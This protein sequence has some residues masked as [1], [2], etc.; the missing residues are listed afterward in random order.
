MLSRRIR[1]QGV[2]DIQHFLRRAVV[3]CQGDHFGTR[4]EPIRKAQDVLDG[5]GA[6]GIDRLGVVAD[7]REALAIGLQAVEDL[8]LQFIGVL[9][10]VDEHVVE[11]RADVLCEARVRHHQVPVE[12]QIVVIQHVVALFLL[13]VAAV[14]AAEVAFPLRAP[15]VLLFQRL[16]QRA[17]GVH[18]VGVDL[19]AGFLAGETL[20]L[21][22]ESEFLANAVHDVR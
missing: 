21:G 11:I 12:Q 22:R 6:E 10:L 20:L 15:G 9:V 4:F 18:A 16:F 3:L 1:H 14:E 7:H 2:R 8:G 5:S 19:H 17:L 13:D